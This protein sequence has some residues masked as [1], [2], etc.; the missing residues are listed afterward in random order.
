[1]GRSG[2]ISLEE[3][4]FSIRRQRVMLDRDLAELYGVETKV[5]NQTFRRNRNRF[6]DGFAF[7]LTAYEQAGLVSV[8]ERFRPL[9]HS[10]APSLAFTDY[11]V[12]ML[13]GVLRSPKAIRVNIRIIQAFVRMRRLAAMD[14]DV[15][16]VVAAL[17]VKVGEHDDSIRKMFEALDRL[18]ESGPKPLPVIGFSR[19][20]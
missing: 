20:E 16:D 8:H 15:R 4:I 14:R 12:A 3:R 18:V 11:G 2:S 19:T 17:K 1:M 10:S 6:P 13:S 7:R 9:K 5:L